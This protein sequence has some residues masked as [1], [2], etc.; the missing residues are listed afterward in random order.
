[1]ARP[2]AARSASRLGSS[3][4]AMARE[5]TMI[6]FRARMPPTSVKTLA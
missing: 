5:F 3:S 4:D 2:A 6:T 1:M